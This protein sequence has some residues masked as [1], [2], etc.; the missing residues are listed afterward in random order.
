MIKSG[1][2]LLMEMQ[3]AFQIQQKTLEFQVMVKKVQ[4]KK[5]MADTN[6]A[7]GVTRMAEK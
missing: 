5:N 6:H 3:L 7:V 2:G 1:N 4:D